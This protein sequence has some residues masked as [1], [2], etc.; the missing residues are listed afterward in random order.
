[1]SVLRR[2][3][4]SRRVPSFGLLAATK[5]VNG[6]GEFAAGERRDRFCG[7]SESEFGLSGEGD[8]RHLEIADAVQ[9]E[10]TAGEI[11]CC[12]AEFLEHG[13]GG[14]GEGKERRQQYEVLRR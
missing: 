14:E 8:A 4:S 12:A 1:M 11:H 10:R 5:R 7:I 13:A 9:L 6:C 2:S 3:S